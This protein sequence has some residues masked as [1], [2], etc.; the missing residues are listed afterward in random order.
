MKLPAHTTSV[1]LVLLAVAAGVY[2]MTVD[3]GKVS[4]RERNDRQ[5]DVFPA[6]R[7]SDIDFIELEQSGTGGKSGAKLRIERRYEAHDARDPGD[8]YWQLTSPVDERADP[9]AVDRFVGDLEF[10][11]A[12][13]KVDPGAAEVSRGFDPPR[14]TGTL[15]MRALVYHFALGGPAPIPE[16]AA[17]FRVDGEGTFVI[18]KDFAASILHGA[19]VYRDRS[20]VPYLS[21]DLGELEVTSPAGT[22]AVVRV[23]DVSFKLKSSGLRASR[24]GMDKVWGALA[25]ARAESFLADAAAERAIGASPIRVVMTPKDASKPKGELLLG[26]ECPGHPEDVVLVRKAPRRESACVPKGALAGLSLPDSALVD[27]RLFAARPDEVEELTLETVPAGFTV[28]LARAGHGWH[29]RKPADRDLGTTSV[30]LVNELVAKL[31]HGEATTVEPSSGPAGAWSPRARARLKRGSVEEVVEL[32]GNELVRRA[33]D[34]AT[35]HVP[36]A[37]GRRLWPSEVVLR[38]RGVFDGVAGAESGLPVALSTACDGV[39]QSLTHSGDRWVLHEPRG[40]A[41]DPLAATDVAGV[42]RNA[43]ADAWVADHDDGTFGLAASTCRMEVSL[44]GEGG[45]RTLAIIL[46]AESREPGGDFYARATTD[47][48][49]FL[50]PR[51]LHDGATTWLIDRGGFRVDRKEVEYVTLSRGAAHA[52]FKGGETAD[53][54]GGG[55]EGADRALREATRRVMDTL[56]ALRPEIVVHLGPARPGEGFDGAA[57]DVR[58][59]LLPPGPRAGAAGGKAGAEDRRREV[60]YVVGDTALMNK[61]RVTYLRLDGVDATF[62]A[63][64]ERVVALIDAL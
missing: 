34:G 6:Y 60:H 35:L 64:H 52:V 36:A 28:D 49:V 43:Q 17:Y 58:V 41:A 53:G 1:A 24:E 29:E 27:R 59:K 19:D 26:G 50:A 22:L 40:F 15:A 21:L 14:V 42:I 8:G 10:A 55:S 57:V 9:A 18:S 23:D 30:D 13:R 37:F 7:R 39:K 12:I 33:F 51:A 44:P 5:H 4:D 16:G 63:N 61:E 62:A 32:S 38:G 3:Q 20:I 45:E 25:E 54:G 47:D 31:T 2:T 46:G 11:G 56:E 48:A